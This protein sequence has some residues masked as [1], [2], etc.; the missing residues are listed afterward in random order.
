[1]ERKSS[2]KRQRHGVIRI[3]VTELEA[4]QIQEKAAS[5]SM[6][7]P[8]FLRMLGTGFVPKSRLDQKAIA[9]L[10][11]VSAEQARLGGLLKFTILEYRKEK[12][13]F[14]AIPSID[15]ILGDIQSAQAELRSILI[16]LRDGR[17]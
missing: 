16:S 8:A 12:Q 10:A 3:R 15:G 17:R 13:E 7:E 2:E 6:S 4:S 9:Q 11:K 1:M 5:C 14:T